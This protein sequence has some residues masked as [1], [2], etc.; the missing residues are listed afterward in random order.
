MVA[1]CGSRGAV[2]ER[3]IKAHA[4]GTSDYVAMWI[5]SEEPMADIED[6][7]LH[8]AKVTTVPQWKQPDGAANHQ[9][10]FMTTCMETW[11]VADRETLRSHYGA[12]LQESSLPAV[13]DLESRSRQDVQNKLLHA[14]RACKNA[15]AKGKQSYLLLEKLNPDVLRKHLPGFVRVQR[16]LDDKL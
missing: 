16:I 4:N 2:Y 15:Y 1:A 13:H 5:D 12:Q 6:A 3:F 7:W 10:L 14:T 11:F 8:L 9:V